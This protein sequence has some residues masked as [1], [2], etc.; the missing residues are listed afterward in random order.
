[1]GYYTDFNLSAYHYN[2][3]G[4]NP[5]VRFSN[6]DVDKKRIEELEIEIDKMNVF[7]SGNFD[8]GWYGYGK[9]YD[10]ELDM[11]LLSARF[12]EFFFELYGNGE[13]SEDIWVGY[14]VGGASQIETARIEYDEFSP[15]KTKLDKRIVSG[16]KLEELKYSYE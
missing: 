9:W 3:D 10:Y 12:P 16:E 14:F 15:L 4:K 6:P 2:P 8:N 1:M 13:N 7:E 5:D 11:S